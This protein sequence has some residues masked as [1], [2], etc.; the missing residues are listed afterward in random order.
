MLLAFA[1]WS[2]GDSWSP[3][4]AHW[5]LQSGG[6]L[7]NNWVIRSGDSMEDTLDAPQEFLIPCCN[8]VKGFVI[9]L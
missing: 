4:T 8:A 6:Y 3:T 7:S 5:V 2:E 1:L 9:V